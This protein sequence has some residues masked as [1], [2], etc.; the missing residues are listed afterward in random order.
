MGEFAS[1]CT[2]TIKTLQPRITVEHQFSTIVRSW[3]LGV[4][5]KV[6][7]ASDYAGGDLYGGYRQQSFICK[8]YGEITQNRPF[9]YM[10]SRCDP[11]L[12]DHTTTKPRRA[13]QI[14]NYLTLAH[15]GA[16]LAI[17]AI[18]PRGTLNKKVYETLGGI[19]EESMP[20]EA[21][22]T[23]RAVTE[24]AI[25]FDLKSKMDIGQSG[26]PTDEPDQSMPQLTA[27]VGAAIALEEH[28]VLYTVLPNCR[29]DR[30]FDKQLVIVTHASGLTHDEMET[31]VRY[32]EQG[33]NLYISGTTNP[34]LAHRLLGLELKDYTGEAI[35]FVSPTDQGQPYFGD[36]YSPQYP[37][38][39]RAKQMRVSNP[40]GKTVLATL[41]LPYTNPDDTSVFASIHSNPPG[42]YTDSPAMVYGTYG[43]GRVLWSGAA[44]E[45]NE[46]QAHR[47]VFLRLISRLYPHRL[48]HSDAPEWVSFTVF[49]DPENHCYYINCVNTEERLPC[50]A[51]FEIRFRPSK[52]VR[53]VVL[54]PRQEAVGFH[55]DGDE[56]T[57]EVN[58]M[59]LFAMYELR[60]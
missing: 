2:D 41:T 10:T 20:Y 17:D 18:D 31:L 19:F 23:G 34:I 58:G 33:G 3:L 22:M 52:V 44:I 37:L 56:V 45:Q 30:I 11:D 28:H 27:A 1:F 59:D 49:D 60:Y 16:F 13:L 14:H 26:M 38:T 51:T 24:A 12:M 40:H 50:A 47:D 55:C 8:M 48:L 29:I 46:Q 25:L 35:T 5:E 4:N 21:Y 53:D 36:M 15:H 43:K 54:L 32:V 7:E 57:F 39:Y 6:N 9:E 42:I